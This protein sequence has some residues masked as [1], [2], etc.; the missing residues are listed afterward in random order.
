MASGA[1]LVTEGNNLCGFAHGASRF[2]IVRVKKDKKNKG[3]RHMTRTGKRVVRTV[4]VPLACIVWK[5]VMVILLP[6]LGCC[7]LEPPGAGAGAG[8]QK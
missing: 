7:L 3:L 1:P 8:D 6:E 2:F 5:G 4:Y